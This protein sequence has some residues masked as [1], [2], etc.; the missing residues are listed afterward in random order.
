M[1][2][3][4]R[5]IKTNDTEGLKEDFEK[6]TSFISR[7]PTAPDVKLRYLLFVSQ[8]ENYILEEAK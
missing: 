6:L 8:I 7:T 3:L 4:E 5:K 2:E 1:N